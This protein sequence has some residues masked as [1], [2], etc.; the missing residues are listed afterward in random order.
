MRAGDLRH[1]VTIQQ[2]SESNDGRGG[3]SYSWS[4]YTTAWADIRPVTGRERLLAQQVEEAEGD[5]KIRIRYQPGITPEMR[6]LWGS[7]VFAINA[8]LNV[9]ERDRELLLMAKEKLN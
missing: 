6:V 3:V 8:V 7:R 1:S 4:T 9:T 2:A 5:Y